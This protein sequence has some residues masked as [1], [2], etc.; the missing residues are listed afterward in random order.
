MNGISETAA[1]DPQERGDGARRF[2][3]LVASIFLLMTAC[4][5]ETR[6]STSLPS[7]RPMSEALETSG[8]CVG[9]RE[10]TLSPPRPSIPMALTLKQASFLRPRATLA[11]VAYQLDA[12][13]EAADYAERGFYCVRGGFALATRLEKIDPLTKQSLKAPARW[14]TGSAPL[15]DWRDGVNLHAILEAL[16]NADAGSYRMLIFYV[17]NKAVTPTSTA[18]DASFATETIHH[19]T[20][21]LPHDI[22][23]KP[24]TAD[25]RVRVLVYEFRRPTVAAQPEMVRETLPAREHLKAARINL[26]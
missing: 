13:L 20:D 8:A 4:A 21:E 15:V 5:S 12:A 23:S 10:L 6:H 26:S 1:G 17:T 14:R 3:P 2:V 19:A 25:H 22:G 7:R 9:L 24:Y 18:P 16:R 11:D